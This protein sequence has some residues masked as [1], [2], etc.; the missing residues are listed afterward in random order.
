MISVLFMQ[1]SEGVSDLKNVYISNLSQFWSDGGWGDIKYNFVPKFKIVQIILG[2]E[3][4][5]FSHN[6]L[7]FLVLNA[8][9]RL[10]KLFWFD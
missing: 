1:G 2:G 6:F 7:A 5:D 4:M 3:I 10:V 9:L 8:S